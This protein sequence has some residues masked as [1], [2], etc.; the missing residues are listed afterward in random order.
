M[1]RI[2]GFTVITAFI[3]TALLMASPVMCDDV[4]QQPVP[5]KI[6]II[7]AD[8]SE[9]TIWHTENLI[10]ENFDALDTKLTGTWSKTVDDNVSADI[11]TGV[12]Y[13]QKGSDNTGVTDNVV[14]SIKIPFND[15]LEN[16]TL[17]WSWWLQDNKNLSN[18][19]LEQ[20]LENTSGD[21]NKIR[22]AVAPTIK[23]DSWHT[24]TQEITDN[25]T[26]A[27]VYTLKFRTEITDNGSASPN[28]IVWYDNIRLETE[29]SGSSDNISISKN[30]PAM[31]ENSTTTYPENINL[32][33]EE[34]F[35]ITADNTIQTSIYYA[36]ITENV[37]WT[38]SEN[39]KQNGSEVTGETANNDNIRYPITLRKDNQ[40]NIEMLYHIPFNTIGWTTTQTSD[41][42]TLGTDDN[43]KF[44]TTLQLRTPEIK[45]T[46]LENITLQVNLPESNTNIEGNDNANKNSTTLN[47]TRT[48]ENLTIIID[49][50]DNQ[51]ANINAPYYLSKATKTFEN[52]T[53]GTHSYDQI[54]RWTLTNPS[55]NHTYQSV[56]LTVTPSELPNIVEGTDNIQWGSTTLDSSNYT[57]N[58]E[59]LT[60]DPNLTTGDTEIKLEFERE[61]YTSP[62]YPTTT[63]DEEPD[64]EPTATTATTDTEGEEP[65]INPLILITI[66]IAPIIATIL[67]ITHRLN[68]WRL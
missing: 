53:T 20:Y 30:T 52:H 50:L 51:Y 6:T 12:I 3:L 46:V 24:Y 14:W 34:N 37:Q 57:I 27:G 18:L 42:H 61:H 68:Y 54:Y 38:N 66:I 11:G 48:E 43:I 2:K 39:V 33:V 47:T 58:G 8:I 35:N 40:E 19:T 9:N 25:I 60:I 29:Y 63:S 64:D 65:T 21:N 56:K 67:L 10:D 1:K 31:T 5:R 7:D 55:D 32:L 41:N 28:I 17:T 26:T 45:S 59:N 4:I 44:T 23:Q 15:N 22:P 16:A 49:N 36:P 62:T 13:A